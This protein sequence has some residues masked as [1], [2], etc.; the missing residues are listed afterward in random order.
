MPIED[1]HDS[2]NSKHS[3]K[4]QCTLN[5]S[6]SLSASVDAGC[7]SELSRYFFAHCRAGFSRLFI[8]KRDFWKE[9]NYTAFFRDTSALEQQMNHYS[10]GN[11]AFQ[12]VFP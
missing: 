3:P 4:D 2:V 9:K 7:V 12:E 1:N 10:I 8:A 11:E 5:C 6:N